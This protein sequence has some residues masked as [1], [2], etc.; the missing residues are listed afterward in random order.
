MKP[1]TVFDS[2]PWRM[3]KLRDCPDRRKFVFNL[4]DK[5]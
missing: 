5:I 1:R 4:Q 2:Y 3:N